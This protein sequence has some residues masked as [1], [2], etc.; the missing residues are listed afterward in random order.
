M[1]E[2]H[3]ILTSCTLAYEVSFQIPKVRL[4]HSVLFFI[5]SCIVSVNFEFHCSSLLNCE[6]MN[7]AAGVDNN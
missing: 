5:E 4:S 2:F 6:I 1:L 7:Y 3:S